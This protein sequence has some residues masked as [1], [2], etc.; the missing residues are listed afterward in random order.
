MISKNVIELN[1]TQTCPA[2]Q[3]H[4]VYEKKQFFFTEMRTNPSFCLLRN[5]LFGFDDMDMPL[6]QWL[7]RPMI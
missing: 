3:L 6:I 4:K 5:S 2:K 7:H 1:F